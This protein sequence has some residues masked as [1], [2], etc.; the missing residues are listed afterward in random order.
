MILWVFIE[1]SRVKITIRLLKN[2]Y[3]LILIVEF[4]LSK[5]SLYISDIF[6]VFDILRIYF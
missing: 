4:D 2:Y 3:D 1:F 5:N 6:D